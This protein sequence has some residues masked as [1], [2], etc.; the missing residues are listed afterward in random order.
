MKKILLFTTL[1]IL[2]FS[3]SNNNDLLSE[4]SFGEVSK[5]EL[6][7]NMVEKGLFFDSSEYGEYRY[8]IKDGKFS[9][10]SHIEL[11]SLYFHCK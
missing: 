11:N 3:C 4:I 8:K 9:F 1:S 6:N 7:E 2:L 10:P 5:E